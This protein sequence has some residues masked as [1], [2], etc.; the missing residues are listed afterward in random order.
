MLST[1]TLLL[2]LGPLAAAAAVALAPARLSKWI[3]TCG[4]LGVFAVSLAV[5]WIFP[6]WTDGQFAPTDAGLAIMPSL[7]ITLS[8]GTDSVGLM[9]V[10]ARQARG[11]R[12]RDAAR[13][14]H[15]QTRHRDQLHQQ[16]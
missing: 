16:G 12:A 5:A 15:T 2:I 11:Q 1:L 8:L 3:A 14:H 7:G 4:S 6:H 10:P 9:L 13:D